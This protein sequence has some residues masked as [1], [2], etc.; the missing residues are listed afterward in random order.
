MDGLS[1]RHSNGRVPPASRREQ[2]RRD[3]ARLWPRRATR[4][5]TAEV[6]VRRQPDV[7]TWLHAGIPLT[8]LIDLF[9]PRGP[10]SRRVL[11]TERRGT[12]DP[13][14]AA[15]LGHVAEQLVLPPA[16]LPTS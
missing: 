4:L 14:L 9:D 6:E 3:D 13:W 8:L 1:L 11:S 5:L 7:M 12:S 16:D 15:L 10:N 2:V